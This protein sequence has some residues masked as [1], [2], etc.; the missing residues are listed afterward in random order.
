MSVGTA[1]H[2]IAALVTSVVAACGVGCGGG[3]GDQT[4]GF[5][6]DWTF[7]SGSLAA[8][9]TGIQSPSPFDLTGLGVTFAKVDDATISLTAG[10][11]GCIV[12]FGVSGDA[13]T[14]K[15]NQK[16]TLALG[17]AFGNQTVAVT[18][19][20]LTRTGD[21]IDTTV[22]GAVLF[23]TASGTG[24]L[25]R[26]GLDA[27]ATDAGGQAGAD[28]GAAGEQG[29][30]GASGGD[31]AA[32]AGA[33]GADGGAAGAGDDGGGDVAADS[34]SGSDAPAPDANEDTA[35]IDAGAA[36]VAAESGD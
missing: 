30:A 14:V 16:C 17:K 5:V 21:R 27:G 7:S 35:V 18:T 19:W 8:T 34:S 11:A 32:G 2:R 10:T 20:T 24:V 22:M 12:D 29:S 23:C 31:G 3:S 13:A 26:G 1:K 36:D 33:A 9:C 6:G 25:V 4:T 28:A 15:P